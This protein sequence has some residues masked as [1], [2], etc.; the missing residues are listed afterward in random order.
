L[1]GF[2]GGRQAHLIAESVD[3][4]WERSLSN[5]DNRADVALTSSK[6]ELRLVVEAIPALVWKAGP[7]GN[8]GYVVSGRMRWTELTPP[9]RLGWLPELKVTGS[10][11]SFEK[12]Y[13]RKDSSR[14][15]VLIGVAT[16]EGGGNQGV[17]FVLDL[18]VA[19]RLSRERQAGES[20]AD[21]GV[22]G[23]WA[24]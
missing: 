2:V 24:L 20:P 19:S 7:E 22:L 14:V 10:L 11:Q 12:E 4:T 15:P 17:A 9:E 5:E 13:F 6:R 18:T 3:R 16:F 1:S 21:R 23:R 8:L